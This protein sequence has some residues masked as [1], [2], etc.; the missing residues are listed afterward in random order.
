MMS[1]RIR[2]V[3]EWCR[4]GPYLVSATAI[5]YEIQIMHYQPMTHFPWHDSSKS[6]I[7]LTVFSGYDE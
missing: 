7:V 4:V 3:K 1:G 5:K 6:S 2:L